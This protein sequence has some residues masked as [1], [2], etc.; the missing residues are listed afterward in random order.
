MNNVLTFGIKF[1]VAWTIQF[2]G[3]IALAMMIPTVMILGAVFFVK[4]LKAGSKASN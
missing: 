2:T 3:S 4:C 1:I